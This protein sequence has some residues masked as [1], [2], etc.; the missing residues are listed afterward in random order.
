MTTPSDIGL[1]RLTAQRL[2]G[3]GPAG[4]AEVVGW[5]TAVQAQD[6]KGALTSVALRTAAR[7]LAVVEA[8][9][10][11]GEVVRSWPMRGTLH[12][13]AAG[14]LRW[15]LDLTSARMVAQARARLAE[16][17]LTDTVV[18]QARVLAV[19]A[20][21]GGRRLGRRDLLAVW[22]GAGVATTGQRGYHLLAHL[23]L[24]GTLCFGPMS[25]GEQQIVLVDEWIPPSPRPDRDEALGELARRYFR[26]HGPATVKDLVRWSGLTTTDVRA[27]LAVARP[28]LAA[29]EV[30]GIEHLMAPETPDLLAT[31]RAEAAD[32]FL[33]PGFDEFILGYGDRTAV[34]PAEYADR[35]VPGRNGVFQPTVV[36]A[37][38]VVGTWKHTGR[39]P[40]RTVLATPFTAF[41]ERVEAA[42]PQRYADLP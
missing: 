27:G 38:R 40:N 31:L 16:L 41:T 36:S 15:I 42:I 28:G 19:E 17:E 29:V 4:P 25:D 8:A 32:V 22:D 20:L 30:D 14:D 34:V 1:L 9:L 2:A 12:L 35:I 24:T 39:A 3:P 10:D 13:V 26:G 7:S 23:A 6:L 21:T 33:L 11:A 18:E 37:G 5:L